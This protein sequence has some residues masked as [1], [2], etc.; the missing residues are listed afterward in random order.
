MDVIHKLAKGVIIWSN[1]WTGSEI[2]WPARLRGHK[3]SG[4]WK[5]WTVPSPPLPCPALPCPPPSPRLPSPPLPSPSPP[6][7]SSPLPSLPSLPSL[8]PACPAVWPRH[9][10]ETA[11]SR[12]WWARECGAA[13]RSLSENE[14]KSAMFVRVLRKMFFWKRRITRAVIGMGTNEWPSPLP[15]G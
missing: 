11:V 8:P 6:R 5:V 15:E 7:P 4:L 1:Q 12:Y 10:A 14:A 13:R 9:V 2:G 3:G